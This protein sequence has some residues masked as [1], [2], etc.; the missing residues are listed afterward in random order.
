MNLI[1]KIAVL[2]LLRTKVASQGLNRNAV[3]LATRWVQAGVEKDF[4]ILMR[5]QVLEGAAG[6]PV[7][8]W[9]KKQRMGLAMAQAHF[10][11]QSLDPNWFS[12]TNT[13][14]YNIV[15]SCIQS[16]IKRYQFRLVEPLDILASN[17]M[18]LG[19]NLDPGRIRP[20][21]ATGQVLSD[22][23]KDGRETP[24]GVAK[25]KLCKIFSN[26]VTVEKRK[27]K[28]MN[29]PTNDEGMIMDIPD[30]REESISAPSDSVEIGHL[31]AEVV[32]HNLHDPLGVAI[33][34]VMRAS[35]HDSEPML[36]W[37]D[38]I[39]N[40]HRFPTQKEVAQKAGMAPPAFQVNHWKKRWRKFFNDIRYKTSLI[41]RLQEAAVERGLFWDPK[42][43]AT[44]EIETILAPR[45]KRPHA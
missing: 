25:S 21:Y 19:A 16:T 8:S 45:A 18:G 33:R 28:D 30:T 23:I 15:F 43:L 17:L 37:L 44:A 29:M 26:K 32:F 35:W 7:D 22:G 1:T 12:P 34:D 2:K 3:A 13:G 11:N 40:E 39:E 24:I 27:N 5:L 36:L 42:E 38:I 14:L 20:C 4:D 41:R 10:E 31:L 6:V 9:M